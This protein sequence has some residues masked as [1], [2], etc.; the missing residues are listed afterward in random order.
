MDI[1]TIPHPAVEHPDSFVMAGR[2]RLFRLT[3]KFA[4][5]L[6]NLYGR[7]LAIWA[8]ILYG[9]IGVL[10]SVGTLNRMLYWSNTIQL[11]FCAVSTYVGV[12]ML[13]NQRSQ[14]QAIHKALTHIANVVDMIADK[15]HTNGET[16]ELPPFE[17]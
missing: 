12:K 2:R 6:A 16:K 9:A 15:T 4:V 14:E 17:Y 10:V 7:P 13:K 3:D 11:V 8:F 1:Q 5:W